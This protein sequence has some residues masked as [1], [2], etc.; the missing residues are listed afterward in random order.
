M[1]H[2]PTIIPDLAQNFIHPFLV[3]SLN[4][5]FFHQ[6][7]SSSLASLTE[8]LCSI[9]KL[10]SFLITSLNLMLPH[11]LPTPCSFHFPKLLFL[12]L[13]TTPLHCH[14]TKLPV[15]AHINYNADLCH[16]LSILYTQSLPDALDLPVCSTYGP[17]YCTAPLLL[18]AC[19]SSLPYL[20]NIPAVALLNHWL[21]GTWR[22][23]SN[24]PQN[25][26]SYL[27]TESVFYPSRIKSSWT[28][29]WEPHTSHWPMLFSNSSP[30]NI[31]DNIIHFLQRNCC[32]EWA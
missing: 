24:L 20:C 1:F 10:H 22:L 29:L 23:S 6:P 28:P 17:L 27:P 3:T 18:L 15:G 13:P 14:L 4:F 30:D 11:L 25:I 7:T 32:L 12:H 19:H 8:L 16:I 9:Y 21:P 31:S 5:L 2:L 26:G